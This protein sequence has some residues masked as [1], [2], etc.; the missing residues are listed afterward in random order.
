MRTSTSLILAL[1]LSFWVFPVHAQQ[2]AESDAD[3]RP[4]LVRLTLHSQLEKPTG[5]LELPSSIMERLTDQL[6]L[7]KLD[8]ETSGGHQTSL[9]AEFSF[10]SIEEFN[11]WY[12]GESAQELLRLLNEGEGG[13][14]L[15]LQIVRGS[16]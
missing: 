15:A 1:A 11:E 8:V 10:R 16:I 12:E 7:T 13:T 2:E 5:T 4:T 6:P 9:K 14:R 3:T